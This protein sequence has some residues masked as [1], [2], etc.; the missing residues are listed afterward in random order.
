M[1]RF[2]LILISLAILT[3]FS[4]KSNDKNIHIEGK[5][6]QCSYSRIYLYKVSP[7]GETIVDSSEIRN[8]IFSLKDKLNKDQIQRTSP[9]FYKLYI[10]E[11]NHILTIA[12][13]GETIHI[14]AKADS[15]VKTYQVTGGKEAFLVHELDMQLKSFID[16]VET[17]YFSYEQNKYNDTVKLAIESEYN[18]LVANHQAFL[19]HFIQ[20]NK[21]TLATLNAF[22][23][24]FNRRIFLPEQ[25][26]ISLLNEILLN[27]KVKYPQ[28]EN[29][30]FIESRI[31]QYSK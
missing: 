25:D 2:T 10:S 30:P 20:K 12:S 11:T 29:I 23:Q 14:E 18:R 3:L 13:K 17:L 22:Y 28:N 6:S 15:L 9:G 24:S 21:G 31:D 27:I 4:C 19:I 5:L 16:S 26:N 1:K 8:G 7:D